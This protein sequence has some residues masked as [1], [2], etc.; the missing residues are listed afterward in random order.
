MARAS[1]LVNPFNEGHCVAYDLYLNVSL[2]LVAE[3]FRDIPVA[4]RFAAL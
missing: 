1:S 2:Q 4:E 3:M